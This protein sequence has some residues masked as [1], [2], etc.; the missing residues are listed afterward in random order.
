MPT[1]DD[2]TFD[3]LKPTHAQMNDMAVARAAAAEY[4]G[5][6]ERLLSDGPDKTYLLR[7]LREVAMWVNTALT[8]NHDGSPRVDDD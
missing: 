3:Y 6:L 7:K 5:V 8:R 4:V 1:L 2:S